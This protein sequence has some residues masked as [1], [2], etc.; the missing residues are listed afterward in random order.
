MLSSWGI[1]SFSICTLIIFLRVLKFK[2]PRRQQWVGWTLGKSV[3]DLYTWQRFPLPF[4]YPFNPYSP[5]V[6]PFAVQPSPPTR[7]IDLT[8]TGSVTSEKSL[9]LRHSAIFI[10]K[11]ETGIITVSSSFIH[12]SELNTRQG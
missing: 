4:L 1:F 3:C 11:M 10:Y 12:L 9:H 8:R 7:S 5:V 2:A 6:P